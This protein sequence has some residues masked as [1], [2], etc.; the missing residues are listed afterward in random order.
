MIP[1]SLALI[2]AYFDDET[3]GKAIGTWSAFTT[4]ASI[5]APAVGGFLADYGLWRVIFFLTVP[6]A[7]LSLWALATHVPES[8]DEEAPRELDYTGAILISIGLVGIV[9]GATEIGR[10]RDFS[11]PV[12]SG[13]I[14][15]GVIALLIFLF[16]EWGS[17]HPLMPLKLFKSRTFTGVNLLTLLL[18]GALGGGLFFL[19]LNL[20]QVQGYGATAAGLAVLPMSLL[21]MLMSRRAGS[22][23][24]TYGPRPPLIIGPIIVGFGYAALALPGITDG[25][26]DFWLTYLP[27]LLLLGVGMGLTVA[28]LTTSALGSVPQ[29]NSGIASGVNNLMS[30][31]AGVLAVAIMGG[32]ALV[33]FSDNLQAEVQPL[34]LSAEAEVQLIANSGDL[35]GMQIPD[36]V[37][38]TRY[39]VVDTAINLAF[40]KTFRLIMWIAA[41]LCW[42]SAGVAALLVEKELHHYEEERIVPAAD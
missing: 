10:T 41:I 27:G 22:F 1:G 2:S 4:G 31:A 24:D 38:E 16:V 23:V 8:Y 42:L 11:N 18:Y 19:P 28:P 40:V 9:Y 25:V 7:L 12:L 36:N 34:N 15:V 13:A 21:L 37:D 17:D 30:R 14:A 33:T 5:L 20:Q 29:H 35:A 39:D 26:S 32:V 3:R 6:L